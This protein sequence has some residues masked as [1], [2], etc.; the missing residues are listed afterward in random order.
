M[1]GRTLPAPPL[2]R[3]S[4]S[5]QRSTVQTFFAN[6]NWE[7]HPPEVQEIKLQAQTTQSPLSLTLSVSQFF[8]AINWDGNTIAAAPDTGL[9]A[10]PPE[11]D[12]LTLDDFSSLF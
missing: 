9:V 11:A 6:F 1:T 10:L 3:S 4:R 7:N 5:W 8:A 2:D 12:D